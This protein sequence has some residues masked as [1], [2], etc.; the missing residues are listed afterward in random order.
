M[1]LPSVAA[2]ETVDPW[3]YVLPSAPYFA[4]HWES[5]LEGLEKGLEARRLGK[6]KPLG[7]VIQE[8]GLSQ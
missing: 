4:R 5:F 1:T 6:V 3:T 7:Q 8:L 2:G